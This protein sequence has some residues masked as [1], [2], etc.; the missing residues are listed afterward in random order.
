[1]C[2][3]VYRGRGVSRL[4]CTYAVT[5]FLFMFLSCGVLFYLQK[6]FSDLFDKVIYIDIYRASFILLL[7]LLLSVNVIAVAVS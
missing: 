4:M 7:L 3:G 6:F 2:T 5:L 1:M